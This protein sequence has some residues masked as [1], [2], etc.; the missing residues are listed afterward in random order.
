AVPE[1]SIALMCGV[2]ALAM[3]GLRHRREH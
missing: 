2:A 3:A 1:P